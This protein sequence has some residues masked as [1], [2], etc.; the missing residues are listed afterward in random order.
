MRRLLIILPT[1]VVLAACTDA[2]PSGP[3]QGVKASF[4]PGAVVNVIRVDALDSLP[5]RG[6][7][8]VAPDGVLTPAGFLDVDPAP[9]TIAGRNTGNDPWRSS[10]LGNNGIPQLPNAPFAAPLN[11][12]DRLLLMVST[13][14]ITLPDPV[15]YRRNW[16]NYHIRVS[17]GAGDNQT[18][19]RDIA[20]PEPPPS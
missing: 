12:Q 9:R 18:D 17:F 11:A 4:P 3:Q 15:A 19:V 2:P 5:L 6:A 7:D 10:M 14:E 13:A 8:L 20:A 16:Q 1:A